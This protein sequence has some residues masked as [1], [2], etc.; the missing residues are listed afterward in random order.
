[1]LHLDLQ[2]Q[3]VTKSIPIS[4]FLTHQAEYTLDY[5]NVGESEDSP[6]HTQL[7]ESVP[8]QGLDWGTTLQELSGQDFTLTRP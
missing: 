6:T 5:R 7:C 1:M 2:S 8:E 4:S 3:D